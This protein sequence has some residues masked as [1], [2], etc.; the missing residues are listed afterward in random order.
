MNYY[1][2]LTGSDLIWSQLTMKEVLAPLNMTH[3][4][5]GPVPQDLIPD[6]GVPG[7]ENWADLLV[8]TGYDPVAGMWVSYTLSFS[9]VRE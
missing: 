4:F 2:N 3:S 9:I 5:F 8:G 7:G 1:N 6:V